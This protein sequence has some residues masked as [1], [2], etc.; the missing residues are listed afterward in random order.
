[1]SI[2][3]S[4]RR[5]PA[6]AALV[7]PVTKKQT[8]GAAIMRKGPNLLKLARKEQCLALLNSMRAKNK[9]NGCIYRVF[10][11]GEVQYL[12]PKTPWRTPPS[13]R[14]RRSRSRDKA[15]TANVSRASVLET[16][17]KRTS[18][19]ARTRART[20]RPRPSTTPREAPATRR[21]DVAVA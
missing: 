10:P 14:T 20:S 16:F 11:S 5:R 7:F 17:A 13:A 4:N 1:M 2:R 15:P 12:H 21:A 18:A 6:D 8:G 9:I 3:R 19:S